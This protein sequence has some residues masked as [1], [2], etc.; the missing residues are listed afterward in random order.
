MR[1]VMFILVL[2][3]AAAQPSFAAAQTVSGQPT[4]EEI[5]RA[6]VMPRV[7]SNRRLT[8]DGGVERAPCPLADA[9]YKDI[10]VDLREVRVARKAA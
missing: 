2:L 9:A 10:M 8:I 1:R 3:G 4:R 7:P 5:E 6:P